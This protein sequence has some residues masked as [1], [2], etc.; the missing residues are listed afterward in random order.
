MPWLPS[1][2]TSGSTIGVSPA[3]WARAAYLARACAL[4]SRQ[5]VVGRPSPIRITA[6][7]LANRA[8]SAAYSA[9]RSRSPSSPS[10]TTSSGKPA[11]GLVP[12]STLMPGRMPWRCNRSG[13]G[14]PSSVRC[15]IVSSKRITPLMNRDSP[16]V[17]KSIPR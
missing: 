17:S 2:R 11:S 14:V 16:S 10:V 9:S 5:V 7:H 13:I 4:A 8:P 12:P 15:R 3:S 1:M 6:R